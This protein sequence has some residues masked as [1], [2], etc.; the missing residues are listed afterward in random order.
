MSA[1]CCDLG[2]RLAEPISGT[3]LNVGLQQRVHHLVVASCSCRVQWRV[4]HN[5][6]IVAELGT[7]RLAEYKLIKGRR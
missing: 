1:L 7:L 3:D 6:S 4:V 2:R 5:V